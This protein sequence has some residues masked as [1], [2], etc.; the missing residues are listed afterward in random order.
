MIDRET[1]SAPTTRLPDQHCSRVFSGVVGLVYLASM[2]AGANNVSHCRAAL[3][4]NKACIAGNM[5][6]CQ[7]LTPGRKARRWGLLPVMPEESAPAAP[8]DASSA[9]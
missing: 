8:A 1:T 4:L 6:A 2:F 3:Q 7:T 5:T 9:S